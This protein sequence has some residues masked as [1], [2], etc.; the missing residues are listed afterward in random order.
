MICLTIG[1]AF[2]FSESPL[3]LLLLVNFKEAVSMQH[4]G[5]VLHLFTH[6]L[7]GSLLS[8]GYVPGT[9]RGWGIQQ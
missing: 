3:C 5:S 6:S 1:I 8:A 2:Y 9:V 4:L 7:A